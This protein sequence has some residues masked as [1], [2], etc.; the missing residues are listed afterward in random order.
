MSLSD[1]QRKET[2]KEAICSALYSMGD[3]VRF[4]GET[5]DSMTGTDVA[6]FRLYAD[7]RVDHVNIRVDPKVLMVQVQEDVMDLVTVR[8]DWLNVSGG[9]DNLLKG[10]EYLRIPTARLS[11]LDLR[12]AVEDVV[13]KVLDYY[14]QVV[15]GTGIAGPI[16]DLAPESEYDGIEDDDMAKDV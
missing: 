6:H 4:L 13:L 10:S 14:Q 16:E 5:P 8:L 11:D 3:F 7:P 12:Q 9:F 2:A 1:A 15:S